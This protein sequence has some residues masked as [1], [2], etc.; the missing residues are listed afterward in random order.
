MLGK[1]LSL[2]FYLKKP[3]TYAAGPMPIYL[4][5]TLD[6]DVVELCTSRKCEPKRWDKKAEGVIGK[7]EDAR[8]LNHHL[9]AFQ[10]KVFEA[11]LSLVEKGKDV[12]AGALKG[13]LMGKQ[14]VCKAVLQVFKQHNE[15]MAALVG[16]DFAAGTLERYETALR[17]AKSFILWKYG[18]EDLDIRKLDFE[19]ISEYEFWL[20]S[21]R[22]CGH[23][24]AIKYI[25]NFRKIINKCVR[26]GWLAKD[27]FTGYKM[28]KRE[29]HREAL[30]ASELQGIMNKQFAIARLSLVRDI[31]VFC[32]FTGLAYADIKKLK[33][34]EIGVGVDGEKWIFTSRQKTETPSRIPLLPTTLLLIERYSD[35]PQCCQS[36]LLLPVLSNQKMNSYLKEIADVCGITKN[37]TCHIA[38][39]TFA[40]TVT[41]SN[42]VPIETVSKMLGHKVLR[43]TQLYA[44]ITDRKVGDDMALLRQ[45]LNV[46]ATK[47]QQ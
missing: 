30:T 45:K 20:K 7:S 6:G 38:R 26:S 19:F 17:H 1:N 37:F 21:V 35:H 29:V 8:E 23:N 11:R 41:L 4:R 15:Q 42:G 2:L 10:L 22:K 3:K 44:K 24:S 13:L 31:F 25:A 5:I 39:H 46:A 32:C 14:E 33:R 9:N 34:S 28:T 27:P 47:L 40:T 12:T 18:E 43:T 36:G 16:N